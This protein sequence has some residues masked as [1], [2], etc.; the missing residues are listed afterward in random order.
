MQHPP[1]CT[2]G[3]AD[4]AWQHDQWARR[5]RRVRLFDFRPENPLDL[6]DDGLSNRVR[7][8]LCPR[9]FAFAEPL[10]PTFHRTQQFKKLPLLTV[11]NATSMLFQKKCRRVQQTLWIW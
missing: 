2:A 9:L 5:G 10:P 3:F 7:D 4:V 8:R 11:L 6:G 1:G